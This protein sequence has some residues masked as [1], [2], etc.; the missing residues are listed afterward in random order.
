MNKQMHN[1][2]KGGREGW[3]STLF[4][5]FRSPSISWKQLQLE[6]SNLARR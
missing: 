2:V 3:Q 6:T 5:N 4:W 1:L